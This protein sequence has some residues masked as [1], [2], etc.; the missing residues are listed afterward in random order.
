M[1]FGYNTDMFNKKNYFIFFVLIFITLLGINLI[2]KE[3]TDLYKVKKVKDRLTMLL[4]NELDVIKENALRYAIM[5]SYND[6]IVESM[7]VDDEDKGYEILSELMHVIKQYTNVLL[8]SQ[9]ITDDLMIFSRSW[10][11][12]FSGMPID[13]YRPDLNYFKTNKKPRS[14]IE[15]GRRL[16]IKATVPIYKEGEHLGFVEILQFFEGITRFFRSIGVELYVMMDDKYRDISIFMQN[17]PIAANRYIVANRL[18]NKIHLEDLNT[19]DMDRL[20]SETILTYNDK[21]FFYN[22]MLNGNGESIGGFILVLPKTNLEKF[23][24]QSGELSTFTS[25]TRGELYEIV[26]IKNQAELGYK[27]RY[28]KELIY[29]KDI[30]AK[31]DKKFFE[32]E[33]KEIL[34]QYTKEELIGIILNYNVSQKIEGDIK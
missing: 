3:K 11:N 21:Y 23:D 31:E 13:E 10:D 22:D 4:H 33:A 8:R 19:I 7:R 34:R 25:F 14:A 16:G 5:I 18:Y 27:S 2:V 20:E 15:L 28:D 29:L 12:S 30:V 17:N 1:L 26:K 32:E 9:I 6:A 24:A